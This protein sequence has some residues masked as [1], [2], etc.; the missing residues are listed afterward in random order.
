MSYENLAN[1]VINLKRKE[2]CSGSEALDEVYY[3]HVDDIGVSIDRFRRIVG[4]ILGK[5]NKGRK[6]N[7][8]EN[9]KEE[10]K[11]LSDAQIRMMMAVARERS[12]HLIRDP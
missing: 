8:E 6:R 1:E 3:S 7:K 5:R 11:K 4:S 2:G 10:I 12:D 9:K